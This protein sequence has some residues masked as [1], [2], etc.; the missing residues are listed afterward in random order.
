MLDQILRRLGVWLDLNRALIKRKFGQQSTFTPRFVDTYIVNAFVDGIID[1]IGEVAQTPDHELRH[2][3]DA[4]LHEFIA[5]LRFEPGFQAKAETLKREILRGL[6]LDRFVGAIWGEIKRQ[7]LA[8]AVAETSVIESQL[9]EALQRLAAEIQADRALA[10]RLNAGIS[11][12]VEAGVLRFGRQVSALIEE[13][14]R[15]WDARDVTEKIE[16]EVGSD[17]QFIRL[18][19]TI[20]G[21]TVGLLLQ[22]GLVLLG[23]R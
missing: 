6:D 21:G 20:V 5:R 8:D 19:G 11:A 1:L 12:V 15:R 7:L 14:V 4:A 16:F 17:L 10:D 3:F 18:N 22:A 2:G 23:L 9:V 13:V